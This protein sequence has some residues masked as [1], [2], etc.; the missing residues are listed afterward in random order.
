MRTYSFTSSLV[1]AAL[2]ASALLAASGA[3][4]AQTTPQQVNLTAAPTSVLM[5]DGSLVP[6]WG[7][8]CGTAVSGSTATCAA[9]NPNAPAATTTAPAGWSPV[10]ITIP[11]T[12]TTTTSGTLSTTTLQINLANHLQFTPTGSTT[13]NSIPTSLTIVGQLGGGLGT[14]GTSCVDA[15]GV[16][17]GASCVPSPAH[18]SQVVTWSTVGSSPA[19]TPPS[20]GPRVQSFATEIAATPSTSTSSSPLC[21]GN[22]ATGQ[23][24]LNPGT[25]LIESGTHPSIQGAMGLYGVLVV[26][27]APVGATAGTAYPAAGTAPAVTYNAEIPMLFGEIDPVQNNAV[28]AAVGTTGFNETMV[29]SGQPGGCGNPTSPTYHQC[30]PPTVNYTPLYY[31][32]NGVAFNKTSATG[33]LF[34]ATPVTATAGTGQVLVRLVNAGS[35]MHVPSIVG[36]Q[37]QQLAAGNTT[38]TTVNGF[39]LIAEDGN[40]LPG[41]PRVQS[42]VFM[43][44]GKTYDVMIN[45]P[46]AAAPALPIFDRELSLS[47]NATGHD[48]GMLAY[49]NING[50]LLSAA[51]MGAAVARADSYASVVTGQ[52]L[53]VS[54]PSKGVIANDTNVYGVQL[55]GTVAGLTLNADGTFTYTGAP[56][57]FT[58]CANGTVTGTTCSSGITATVT[59]GAAT[60][61]AS[62]GIIC[63]GSSFTSNVATYLSVQTPGV[64]A[65]CHDAAGYPL[66][67]DPTSIVATGVSVTAAA[68]GG[69]IAN[70][71]T[72][73]SPSFTFQAKNSQGTLSAPVNV[74]LNFLTGSGLKV[75]VVDG[76]TLAP[77][78][79]ADYRWIIE[80]DRTF[81]I[82]PTKTTNTGTSIVPTFGT[83]FHTSYMPIVATG[84]TGELSCESGQ[85]LLG[86]P[87]VCDVG[88]G[89]C[90]P[91]TQQIAVDPS[92]VH[93]DPTKRYYISVLPGDA[94]NSFE[95]VSSCLEQTT[96][97]CGHGMG[98]APITIDPVTHAQATA[99]TV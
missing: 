44:A 86:S 64:L 31:T 26:T 63:T 6:M 61:E 46:A 40:P 96:P 24:G 70:A 30:Y 69:F 20:Q 57:T 68:D 90:R 2:A 8:G 71:P 77:L 42:E 78:N 58:Y 98:G 13:P 49:L 87:V 18:G 1:R 55:V 51:P 94:A 21:W 88:N 84:C 72:S 83:S 25:Y 76:K 48:A 82:D 38:G 53:T 5:T 85:T 75:T 56:T 28:S 43:A 73:T 35:R 62:G 34:P 41:L 16:G 27:N 22:C 23:P 92:Q 50:S 19:F 67:L 9:A 45:A 12:S 7:Y 39:S 15:A 99:V 36:S 97:V 81:Y 66:T 54:D 3:C 89:V 80:E 93:L 10:V 33:S 79:P 29:W 37:T 59:L 74:S 32:I 14:V 60:I 4:L 95:D 47:A 65:N 91:G 11:Y 52:T 17:H